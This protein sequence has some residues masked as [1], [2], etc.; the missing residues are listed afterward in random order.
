LKK[1][2][3]ETLINRASGIFYATNGCLGIALFL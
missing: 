3:P 1:N 2:T